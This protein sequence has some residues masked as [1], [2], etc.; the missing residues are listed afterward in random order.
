MNVIIDSLLSRYHVFYNMMIIINFG[1][2][3]WGRW[4]NTDFLSPSLVQVGIV[5][6]VFCVESVMDGKIVCLDSENVIKIM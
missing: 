5:W 3:I 4:K 2:I 6:C 1:S